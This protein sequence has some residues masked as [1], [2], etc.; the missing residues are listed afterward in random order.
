VILG[1]DL[2][3]LAVQYSGRYREHLTIEC[4]TFDDFEMIGSQITVRCSGW[5]S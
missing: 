5:A 3:H 1:L 2:R 4:C